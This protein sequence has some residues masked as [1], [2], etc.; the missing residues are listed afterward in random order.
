M[1]IHTYER[2]LKKRK[3]KQTWA[4][5]GMATGNALKKGRG[6]GFIH[7]D[8]KSTALLMRPGSRAFLP[9]KVLR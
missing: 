1:H 2:A 5:L 9:Y 6:R 7:Q 3:I 8:G 4:L